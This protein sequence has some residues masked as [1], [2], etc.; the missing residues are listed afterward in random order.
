[1]RLTH[2]APETIAATTIAIAIIASDAQAIV[3]TGRVNAQ[4]SR[5][6]HSASST[7]PQTA[8]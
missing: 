5:A 2:S 7:T 3:D 4:T 1:M 8:L 6:A